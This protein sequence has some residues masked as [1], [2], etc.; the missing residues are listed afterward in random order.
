MCKEVGIKNVIIWN[1]IK[2]IM[3]II[4]HKIKTHISY[5]LWK[6]TLQEKLINNR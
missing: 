2:G 1:N 6:I 4:I 3:R 5:D